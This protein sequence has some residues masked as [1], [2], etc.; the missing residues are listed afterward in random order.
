M[1]R[2][3]PL[4]LPIALSGLLLG[5]PAPAQN[6]PPAS[7]P[8]AGKIKI[9]SAADLPIHTYPITGKASALVEDPARM[10]TL[11]AAVQADI[12][13]DLAKYDIQD[14]STLRGQYGT[15]L[16]A[17]MV[18]KDY[19]GA[20]ALLPTIRGL[21][22]KPADIAASGLS[23]QAL[24]DALE[25]PGADFHATLRA[26]L[27]RA[28]KAA[29]YALISDKIKAQKGQAEILSRGLLVGQIAAEI[30]PSAASGSVS[31]D[32]AGELLGAAYA[33]QYVVPNKAD[34]IAAYSA[35]LD[36]NKTAQ[37]P[38][39]W[40]ARDVTF[41]SAAR[42]TPVEVGIWD[43]GTDISLYRSHLYGAP[44][45][46]YD[47]HSRRTT[48]LL[49]PLPGGKANARALQANLKGFEDL[50]ANV[51][52]PEATALKG[53]LASLPPAEVKPF[54]EGVSQY[55]NY[56]HGTHVTGIALRGDPAARLVVCRITFDYHLIPEAPSVAQAERDA[57]MYRQAVAYFKSRGVRVVNMS[58]G[59]SLKDVEAD[60]EKTGTGGTPAQRKVLA[61]RIYDI[62][63]KGFADAIRTA[64][65]ILFVAAAGN[66][67]E[68]ILFDSNF[69]SGVKAPNLLVVGAVDQ[70]GEQ[71][72]FTSFGNVDVY[73]D[74]FEVPSYVPGGATLK[75]SGTSMA[76]PEVTNLA[77]KVFAAQPNLSPVQAKAA[78][79]RGATR[80][81]AGGKAILLIDPKKTLMMLKAP[82]VPG[83]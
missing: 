52:S 70:A 42:L 37:K 55:A 46:A 2:F 62:G 44:G 67:D 24:L 56:A 82:G 40:A 1:T 36:A 27:E 8:A 79:V 15:L 18:Q 61:K 4:A 68:D 14:R 71:T 9:T 50:Q 7:V 34:L 38:D 6:T 16:I 29:P 65:G 73:A 17:A 47:L 39:I 72:S 41:A 28:F 81:T 21:Q 22:D 23:T 48:G 78:I 13:S 58:W 35:V 5:S 33:L 64:P 63:Y 3:L 31:G 11:A 26:N 77:A 60:L 45:I 80:R 43:S 20:R 51:D 66:S 32:V 57:L 76:S 12:R 75:L 30:D 69:P 53:T 54:I 83:V 25:N 49:Y 59:G 74:G 19:A 10:A